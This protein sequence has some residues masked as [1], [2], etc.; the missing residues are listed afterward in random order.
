MLVRDTGEEITGKPSSS[1]LVTHGG[2]SL[3]GFFFS[4][5]LDF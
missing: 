1:V 2:N 4:L 3:S 5:S